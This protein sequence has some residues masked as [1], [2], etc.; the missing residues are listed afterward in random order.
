M[1][2]QN[3][4]IFTPHINFCAAG[5]KTNG[6]AF[7]NTPKSLQS[8]AATAGAWFVFGVG[9]DLVSRKL[10]FTKSPTKN[11]LIINGI[12]ASGA[13]IYTGLKAAC[14]KKN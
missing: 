6:G 10:H 14:G 8:G 3:I 4:N 9:L 2:V 1:K 5:N 11:S 12:I 13:G 7:H